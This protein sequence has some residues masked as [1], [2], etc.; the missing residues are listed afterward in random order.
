ME[1]IDNLEKLDAL[2]QQHTE[3]GLYGLGLNLE[4]LLDYFA[5]KQMKPRCIITDQYTV[6]PSSYADNP[7]KRASLPRSSFSETDMMLPSVYRGIPVCRRDSLTDPNLYI[8]SLQTINEALLCD[9]CTKIYSPYHLKKESWITENN[10]INDL[11]LLKNTL[12]RSLQATV[13]DF[14][15]E[16]HLV[17]HCNL[18]C[19]GC[20]HFSPLAEPE[21]LSVEVFEQDIKRLSELTS[22][23]ARF[24]N[25][26]G[27][28]PLLHPEINSFLQIA[29]T[30]FPN[31]K[32]SVV[33]N[34]LLVPQ[35]SSDFW[36]TCREQ[37]IVL[38]VTEYPIRF[39]YAAV[40]KKAAD[41]QV[42][43]ESFS[44]GAERYEMWKLSMDETGSGRPIDHF[45][46]C[47]RSNACV[48]CSHGRIYPCPTMAS[49]RHFNRY[50]HTNMELTEFDSIDIYQVKDIREILRFLSDP[51]PFC[52]YCNVE[53]RSYGLLWK[54]S[55]CEKSEWV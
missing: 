31:T 2:M 29:R 14:H 3:I 15:F 54:Q 18:N 32:I 41:E 36:Q 5:W 37:N 52:R 22:K 26:L 49:I 28:E 51:V 9:I 48:F 13:Y 47:Q 46:K 4:I 7:V 1:K 34:G 40:R 10:I 53:N 55:K 11:Q 8:L 33:S 23:T 20:T 17:E 39:D 21:F 25:L 44:G 19:I 12:R 50:F 16:F 42:I 27:G 38:A 43:F 24:I 6:S 35:I 45:M 30:Y